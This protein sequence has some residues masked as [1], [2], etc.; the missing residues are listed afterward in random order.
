MKPLIVASIWL[1]T[2]GVCLALV[3]QEQQTRRAFF[4]TASSSAVILPPAI[5]G[6]FDGGG[7]SAYSGRTPLEK[8]AKQKSYRDRIVA[9]VKDFNTLGAAIETGEVDGDAWVG[10]FIPYQRREPDSV[11]RTYAALLDLIGVEKSGGGAA[12]LLATTYAK[13]N[14]PP[15]NLPQYKKYESLL[16]NFNGIKAAGKAGEAKKAQKEWSKAA[17]VLADY[18]ESVELPAD[19]S[20]PIYK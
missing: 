20:D 1:A 12:L 15:N 10:F 11:G 6:A 16:Q 7:S 4:I 13:P 2:A 8:A 18:L 3:P 17:S 14:K 19:L 9:D 5:S